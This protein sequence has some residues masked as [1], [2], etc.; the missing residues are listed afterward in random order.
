MIRK[1]TNAI[2]Q[3][4]SKISMQNSIWMRK[5]Q[6]VW[7]YS[8]SM[9]WQ[10]Q[11]EAITDA[12]LDMEKEDPYRVGVSVGNGIG[13]LGELSVSIKDCWKKDRPK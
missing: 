1:D 13:S 2:L 3:R 12:A 5:R 11:K 9:Q 10:R 8:A 6:D 4:K 7:N